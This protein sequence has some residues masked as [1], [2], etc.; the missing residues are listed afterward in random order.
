[1]SDYVHNNPDQPPIPDQTISITVNYL[2]LSPL[3]ANTLSL[4]N[5]SPI[6]PFNPSIVTSCLWMETIPLLSFVLEVLDQGIQGELTVS[7]L[8]ANR[9]L[10]LELQMPIN[11]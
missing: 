3:S 5:T 4:V 10:L 11:S 9:E 8:D 6:Y 7:V 2:H 1:M